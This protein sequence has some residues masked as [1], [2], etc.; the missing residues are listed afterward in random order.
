MFIILQPLDLRNHSGRGSRE[1]PVESSPDEEWDYR[2]VYLSIVS[3]ILYAFTL[4]YYVTYAYY[5][6]YTNSS[7]H[8]NFVSTQ[9]DRFKA[10]QSRIGSKSSSTKAGKMIIAV[11]LF[12]C[13]PIA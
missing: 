8:Y 1:H 5:K 3:N 2:I 13:P 4:G 11:A 10:S 9:M 6:H 7:A 12:K